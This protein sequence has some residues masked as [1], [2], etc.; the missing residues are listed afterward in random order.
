MKPKK[1][2]EERKPKRGRRPEIT[3]FITD[4]EGNY[5][6]RVALWPAEHRSER[7]PTYIGRATADSA[8]YRVVLWRREE[9]EE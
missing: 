3:G 2:F 8:Q 4:A 5:I 1:G 7:S 9:G 6:A